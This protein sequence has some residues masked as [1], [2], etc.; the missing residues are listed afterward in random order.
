MKKIYTINYLNPVQTSGLS[1]LN[2]K[3]LS[4]CIIQLK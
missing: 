2:K 3:K 1:D 4:N